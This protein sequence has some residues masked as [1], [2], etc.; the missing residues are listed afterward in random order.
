MDIHELLRQLRAGESVRAISRTLGLSRNTVQAYQQWAQAQ[1][2][3]TGALPP[4]ADLE[5]LRATTF[6]PAPTGAVGRP[7]NSTA[8][9]ADVQALLEQY[10]N[11]PRLIWQQL[12]ERHGAAFTLS[13]AAIWRLTRRLR[14][15][16]PP[17]PTVV[18]VETAPGEVAQVDF[19]YAGLLH[20]DVS[21][22]PRKA[23]FFSMVL[24]WSRHQYAE[25][26]P[27][28]TVPTWLLCHQHAFTFFGGVP[29]RVVL[30]NLKTAIIQAYSHE[31]DV[32]VQRSYR[33]CAEHYNF[34]IDPCWPRQPQHKGKVERGGIGYLRQSFQPLLRP[35]DTFALGNHRLQTWLLTTAG[36]RQHGTTQAQPLGRFEQVERAALRPLPA[37]PYDPAEWKQVKLHRDGYVTFARSY[38]SAPARLVGQTLWLRAGLQEVRVF[39]AA[40]E[41]IATHPRAQMPGERH[42]QTDHLPPEKVR[43][44]LASRERCLVEA[45]AIGPQTTRVITELLESKPVDRLRSA[46]YILTLGQTYTAPRL[47]AACARGLAF[48]EVTTRALKRILEQ[49]LDQCA[50]VPPAVA[51]NTPLQFAR[52]A[53]EL[54]ANL[55]GDAA[56]N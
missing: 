25:L 7:A 15:A 42:T 47:E 17:P 33:E 46:L 4:L 26:V 34:L 30:D 6:G 16:A 44:L 2:L 3:L 55:L 20:D 40:H 38:Y 51:P 35:D 31:Q 13:E 14:A 27:D 29:Q 12:Q 18:R 23:W 1:G 49:G 11:K 36:Q 32:E 41:L 37:Q 45:Q 21:G 28:Q 9:E 56:W 43:G 24:G 10:G 50:F 48:G 22:Q 19:G 54:A 5:R 52:S 53:E 39:T 8:Y